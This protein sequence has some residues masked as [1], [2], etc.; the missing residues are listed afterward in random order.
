MKLKFMDY[1]RAGGALAIAA[2]LLGGGG[3][4][5]AQEV[6]PHQHRPALIRH[7]H[8]DG[9]ATS[10]NWS[11]YAVTGASGSVTSVTGS[12]VIP[13]A[14]CTEA[15]GSTAYA[16]FWVGIDGWN[17][18]SVEQTGTD[19]DCSSGTPEYYAW[20]EFYPAPSYYAGN[21]TSLKVGDVMSATVSYANGTFTAIIKDV[22]QNESY[23]ATFTPAA[24]S[25]RYT[26]PARSSAEWIAEAP[27]CTNRGGTLP[28]ADF[29]PLLFGE[30]YTAPLV[31]T[32]AN[33]ATVSGVTAPIG[34]FGSSAA[35][36]VWSSTMINQN[37]PRNEEANP[38]AADIMAL[39]SGLTSDGTSFKV[40]WNSVGP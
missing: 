13:A 7:M 22:T 18:S 30:D 33:Y 38:P 19:S 32:G 9:T 6:A 10:T 20:Y 16:S 11:G 8:E 12:W 31:P 23:T 14:T 35:T 15:G 26:P 5:Q 39:P 27:C 21:L 36:T 28:L 25:R 1:D 17:S 3:L 34:S 29:S 24:A 4:L 40:T 2:A 37:T